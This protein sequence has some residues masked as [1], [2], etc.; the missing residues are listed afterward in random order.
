MIK[1]FPFGLYA[2]TPQGKVLKKKDVSITPKEY[3][4]GKDKDLKEEFKKTLEKFEIIPEEPD[5]SVVK[6]KFQTS[7]E[8]SE[9]M[10]KFCLELT[11]I[12]IKN[13]YSKDLEIIQL[14]NA[15]EDINNTIN[16]L[17]ERITEW[18]GLHYPESLKKIGNMDK[19]FKI[20]SENPERIHVSKKT[21]SPKTGMGADDMNTKI[22]QKFAE[23]CNQLIKTR[24]EM[25]ADMETS[26]EKIV[27]NLSKVATPS[28]GSKLLSIAGS[29]KKLAFMS[30]S[31]VQVLGAEKAL[32][33]HLRTGAKPPKHGVI[34][35]HPLMQK[36]S[37]KDR[38]RMARALAS[39][40]VTATKVDYFSPDKKDIS[41][42]LIKELEEKLK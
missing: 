26:M 27:P 39:K 35:Q 25:R 29:L 23:S 42:K 17:Y 24:E 12:R 18:Y 9:Y 11:K 15:I 22:I 41:K 34:L 6:Q 13:S 8:F 7:H 21:G 10:N 2:I 5:K 36:A 32:F 33:R 16:K 37:R 31:T 40:I 4:E 38:G 3:S 28:L 1:T 20:L 14:A 19:M 30:S